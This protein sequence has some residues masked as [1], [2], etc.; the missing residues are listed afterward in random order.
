MLFLASPHTDCNHHHDSAQLPCL[1]ILDRLQAIEHCLTCY[2]G[3]RASGEDNGGKHEY[4]L[5]ALEHLLER[6]AAF[7]DGKQ[8]VRWGWCRSAPALAP[9]I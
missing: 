1:A 8:P 4:C 6:A 3:I 7:S 9:R 2:A 5:L